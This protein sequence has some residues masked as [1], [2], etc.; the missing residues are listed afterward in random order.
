MRRSIASRNW[1][2]VRA[3]ACFTLPPATGMPLRIRIAWDLLVVLAMSAARTASSTAWTVSSAGMAS[4][5]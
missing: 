5:V 2:G 1:D 4:G 3:P